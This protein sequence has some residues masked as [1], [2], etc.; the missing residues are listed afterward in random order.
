MRKGLYLVLSLLVVFSLGAVCL[1]CGDDNGEPTECEAGQECC[2]VD[3]VCPIAGWTCDTDN[4]VCVDPCDPDK[5]C[6]E[7]PTCDTGTRCDFA[8]GDCGDCCADA[9]AGEYH[10]WA[11]GMVMDMTTQQG[12]VAALAPISP[13]DA[14]TNPTPTKLDDLETAAD[15]LF[16]TACFDVTEVALG[17][18]I[19]ADDAGW[20]GTGGT[21][22]PTGTPV[23]GW[24]S[25]A[26]K[27]CP[28]Q[29]K[30]FAVPN[31]LVAGLDAATNVD[32]AGFGFVMGFVVDATFTPVDGAV[33]K[34]ADGTD[35]VEVI[36]PNATMT[37]FDGTATSANGIFV[38]PHTNFATGITDITAEKTGMTFGEATVAPKAGFCTFSYVAGQ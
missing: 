35:L 15:G 27:Y 32:S 19:M 13:M 4:N 14:L 31:T 2:L 8:T 24:D 10:I 9:P 7:D 1:H 23:H 18:V 28:E 5:C 26:E 12:I 11:S 25:N 38:L 16:K 34:K 20:D 30:V 29:T 36:Y 33:L 3:P 17:L 37:A 21:Y 22:F 6:E